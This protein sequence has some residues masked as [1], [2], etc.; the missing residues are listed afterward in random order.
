MVALDNLDSVL[1]S[2]KE[3]G[4]V[5]NVNRTKLRV[6]ETGCLIGTLNISFYGTSVFIVV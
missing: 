6:T 4:L 2:E 5:N 3:R 1:L